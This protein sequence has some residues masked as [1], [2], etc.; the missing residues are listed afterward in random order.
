MA[1]PL[2]NGLF[3]IRVEVLLLLVEEGLSFDGVGLLGLELFDG[4]GLLG[5]SL[6][7]DEV[8]QF[9]CSLSLLFLFLLLSQLQLFVADSPELS[10][11]LLLLLLASV[12]SLLALDLKGSALVDGF[13]HV[14]L[15]LLLLLEESVCLIFGLSDLSVKNLLLVVL[16][17]SEFFDL[18]VD[19]ALSLVLFGLEALILTLFLHFVTGI[20]CFS[21]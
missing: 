12:F 21:E 2:R 10:E 6:G 8:S 20:S 17:S 1:L 7:L 16:Q 19:H 4:L 14:S 9:F 13:L 5:V 15:S 11:V 18:T 3:S